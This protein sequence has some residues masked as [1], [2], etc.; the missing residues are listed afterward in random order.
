MK[1]QKEYKD[2]GLT[3]TWMIAVIAIL[4][5]L[6]GG[7]IYW[8]QKTSV[9]FEEPEANE[10]ESST[11]EKIEFTGESEES[12]VDCGHAGPESSEEEA[13]VMLNCMEE[14]FKE[15]KPAKMIISMDMGLLGGEM[16]YSYEIIGPMDN[17]CQIKSGFLKNINPDWNNKEMVCQYDNEKPF[18]DL[19]NLFSEMDLQNMKCKGP[20]YELMI[21]V[22]IEAKNGEKFTSLALEKPE[23][24]SGY[25]W[26][27]DYDSDYVQ[28]IGEPEGIQ[29]TTHVM[30]EFLALKLGKTK[31]RFSLES[32][33]G[34]MMK[35][36]IGEV[37][38]E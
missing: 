7:G 10:E 5:V 26:K 22:P 16:S 18:F 21:T 6:I 19:D 25:E 33:D 35:E 29:S 13:K 14:R 36:F 4:A 30:Y 37:T 8:W 15:C 17:S 11:N 9:P 2:L 27:M 12:I 32:E 31:M 3:T 34:E 20:L 28:F 1:F 38:I 23:E 24:G